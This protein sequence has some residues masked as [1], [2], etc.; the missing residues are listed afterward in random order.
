MREGEMVGAPRVISARH[1]AWRRPGAD[2]GLHRARAVVAGL[3]SA[4]WNVK[5][6]IV[7]NCRT[8]EDQPIG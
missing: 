7:G 6:V 4:R 3:S 1:S 2:G 8:T 5:I